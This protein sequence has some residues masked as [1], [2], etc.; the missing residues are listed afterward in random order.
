MSISPTFPG[1]Y[2]ARVIAEANGLRMIEDMIPTRGFF[3]RRP[4]ARLRDGWGFQ[5]PLQRI[6]FFVDLVKGRLLGLERV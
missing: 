5:L 3:W 6:Q 4:S 2:G 1:C